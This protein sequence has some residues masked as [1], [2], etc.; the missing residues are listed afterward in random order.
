MT[1]ASVEL[2]W[3]RFVVF[4]IYVVYMTYAN[5]SYNFTKYSVQ[6]INKYVHFLV[7]MYTTL[8]ITKLYVTLDLHKSIYLF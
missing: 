1:K 4:L 5:A 3:M 8:G 7:I 6:I 2:T